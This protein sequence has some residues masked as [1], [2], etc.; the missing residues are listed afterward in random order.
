ML[1]QL[2]GVCKILPLRSCCIIVKPAEPIEYV[3]F[4]EKTIQVP[5]DNVGA[6][7]YRIPAYN[8]RN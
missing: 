2:A 4:F 3:W 5:S 6:G 1:A 8:V 7:R